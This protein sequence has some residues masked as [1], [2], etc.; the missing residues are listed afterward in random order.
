MFLDKET[1]I[2][3]IWEPAC[4]EGHIS[5]VVEK[6]YGYVKNTDLVNRGF[7]DTNIDFLNEQLKTKVDT[8]ITN[9]PFKL[10]TEFVLQSKRLSKS[11]IC[12]FGKTSYLEGVN[13][14]KDIWT[15]KEFPLKKIYQYRHRLSIAKNTIDTNVNGLMPFCWFVF[16]K[17]Y[18]GEP[19]IDWL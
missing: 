1:L 15:D 18:D 17:G 7:G 14:H 6:K 3:D 9:P 12:L 2:G 16:E 8:I 4:G 5:K 11:K 19:T 13:R 10:F